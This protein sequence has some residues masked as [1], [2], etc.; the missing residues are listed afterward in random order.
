MYRR[1]DGTID[2]LLDNNGTLIPKPEPP[3]YSENEIKSYSSDISKSKKNVSMIKKDSTRI[4]DIEIEN[5]TYKN[6]KGFDYISYESAQK[7]LISRNYDR[8]LMPSDIPDI[9]EFSDNSE[10]CNSLCSGNR[11]W[12]GLAWERKQDYLIIYKQPSGIYMS[13]LLSPSGD[14]LIKF[15]NKEHLLCKD[16]FSFK[17]GNIPSGISIKLSILDTKLYETLF[18]R[19]QE[20]C[21]LG[22]PEPYIILPEYFSIWPV[23]FKIEN[24]KIFMSGAD[25]STYRGVKE[26]KK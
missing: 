11:E 6:K 4:L 13:E 22:M 16:A 26:I 10:L 8:F 23:G 1:S 17:I 19:K 14:P 25:F 3:I 5:N 2:E 18:G 7:I 12:L 24:E 9:I 20:H 15:Y 21:P